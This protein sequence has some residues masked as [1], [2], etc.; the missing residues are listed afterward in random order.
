VA[1]KIPQLENHPFTFPTELT[2]PAY[3][4]N[5]VDGDTIDVIIAL[6]FDNI[7]YERL[8]IKDIDTP[9]K[10]QA[11]WTEAT[12]LT[13]AFVLGK[14]L[15]IVTSKDSKTFDR[16]VAEV[17]YMSRAGWSSLAAALKRNGFQ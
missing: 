6:P 17:F 9:E 16:Y 7:G 13:K 8:R 4:Y 11:L 2:F 10:G 1:K 15:K 12:E 5:V 3:C 14:Q